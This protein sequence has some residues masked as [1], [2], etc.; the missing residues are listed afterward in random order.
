MSSRRR[1]DSNGRCSSRNKCRSSRW[2]TTKVLVPWWRQQGGVARRCW[3]GWWGSIQPLHG[4]AVA[5]LAVR[6][7]A[8]VW[9]QGYTASPAEVG[10]SRGTSFDV[11]SASPHGR[12]EHWLVVPWYV[13]VVVVGAS[14]ERCKVRA[15]R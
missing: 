4:D 1:G 7:R 15:L 2:G 11:L 9:V 8:K 10:P 12:S 13:Q 5:H 3:R 6:S 14:K